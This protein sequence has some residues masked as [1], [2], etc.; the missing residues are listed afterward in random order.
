MV[1]NPGTIR[2]VAEDS[3]TVSVEGGCENTTFSSVSSSQV[4]EEVQ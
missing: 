3:I 1:V 4:P 2:E